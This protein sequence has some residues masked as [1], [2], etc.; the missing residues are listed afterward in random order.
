M[1]SSVAY[2]ADDRP[3][4]RPWRIL[5]A[6]PFPP[7]LDGRHGGSRAL[8]QL[9]A[10][11][12]VRNRVALLVLRAHDEP[13]VDDVLR[14]ACDVVEEVPIPAVGSSFTA[15]LK[16]R[17]QLRAALLHGTP[18]WAAERSTRDFAA[19]FEDI[20]RSWTPDVVQ[21]EYR[22]MGQFLPAIAGTA[23]AV[24]VDLD[25]DSSE[26]SRSPLLA[27]LE[28]RAWKMLGRA[29]SSHVSVLVA[30]T[31]RD[32]QALSAIAGSTPIMRIP[33]SF[34]LPASPLSPV[35]TE[36]GGIVWVGSFIHPPNVDAAVRLVRDI[37]PRVAARAPAASLKLVGSHAP[38]NMRAFEGNRVT[39]PCEV[40]D[41]RPYLDAATV[42]A[43]PIRHGGGMRVKILEALA[44]GKAIVATP[45]ALEGLDVR[46]GE[47]V[48]IAETDE[49]F[50]DAIVGL[51]ENVDRR[52][53]LARSARRWAEKHLDADQQV[54]A[55]EALYSSIANGRRPSSAGALRVS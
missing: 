24:L 23:P 32:R 15:R 53:A 41:V 43:A 2:M 30:L 31:E 55:Y 42:F 36:P 9:L 6:A 37:F 51:L 1:A 14:N 13:G 49:E 8:A 27:P 38:P 40:P 16:N 54:E 33:L 26:G 48:L 34:D 10:R 5:V 46:D 45:L 50:A 22:I 7:R 18:T 44:Y 39:M 29:A 35:G 19:R 4:G 52:R 28:A 21:L 3:A 17:I 25:P 11:L 12:S 47:Q 20:A